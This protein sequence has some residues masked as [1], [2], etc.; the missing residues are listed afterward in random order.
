MTTIIF[1]ILVLALY[2]VFI[3]YCYCILR[4]INKAKAEESLQTH[5][6]FRKI[7]LLPAFF[8]AHVI[9]SAMFGVCLSIIDTPNNFSDMLQALIVMPF[10]TSV[11]GIVFTVITFPVF[12]IIIF[13]LR[14]LKRLSFWSIMV[15]SI[16]MAIASWY[17][18]DVMESGLGW[19]FW[20]YFVSSIF[21]ALT[22][23]MIIRAN[24]QLAIEK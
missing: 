21:G 2:G 10:F 14:T 24:S 13:I 16:L 20:M 15:S 19:P 12:L 11:I 3:W 7:H 18:L 6:E 17:L 4:K 1:A 8:G 23:W 22:A 5:M 9:G